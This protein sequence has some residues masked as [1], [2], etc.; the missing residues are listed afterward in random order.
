VNQL[1]AFQRAACEW[2]AQHNQ[3]ERELN[4]RAG[5]RD[6]WLEE[7]KQATKGLVYESFIE[8]PDLCYEV[9]SGVDHDQPLPK[10]LL[11][12]LRELGDKACRKIKQLHTFQRTACNW[13]IQHSA[14]KR[15]L[16]KR[17]GRGDDLLEDVKVRAEGLVYDL[18]V[19]RPD[20]CYE[21]LSGVDLEQPLPEFVL[22]W[23]WKLAR[24][25]RR[26]ILRELNRVRTQ[27]GEQRTSHGFDDNREGSER[28][29][30]LVRQGRRGEPLTK[31]DFNGQSPLEILIREK[32]EEEEERRKDLLK[33][34]V[35]R[36]IGALPTPLQQEMAR[37]L[38]ND[39]RAKD[40]A[41]THGVSPA[42]VSLM[43]KKIKKKF[44]EKGEGYFFDLKQAT[45]PTTA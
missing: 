28:A 7:V 30:G 32:E 33:Q 38:L 5:R 18:L 25:A 10:F 1:R 4:K 22:K 21:V 41:T 9:V 36:V 13:L 34:K 24:K 23:L 16:H 17:A 12:K 14:F 42:A 26:Q 45:R 3:F 8:R 15:E 35:A 39:T 29:E 19:E 37:A 44:Y 2:L 27:N 20:L 43:R 11:K 40:I 31:D 6:D